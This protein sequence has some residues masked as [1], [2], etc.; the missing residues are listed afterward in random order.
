MESRRKG[1]VSIKEVASRGDQPCVRNLC[2]TQEKKVS[3]K[4]WPQ[5][6]NSVLSYN[7]TSQARP[8]LL[9]A[10]PPSP[11]AAA[12]EDERQ[13]SEKGRRKRCIQ[14]G[15]RRSSSPSIIPHCSTWPDADK[16]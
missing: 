5:P 4:H 11:R 14:P 8:F 9:L 13:P 12:P 7:S 2:K 10:S 16:G 15:N 3:F 1:R 6:E